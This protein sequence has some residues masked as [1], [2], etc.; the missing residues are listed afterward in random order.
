MDTIHTALT[1]NNARNKQILQS[2][3]KSYNKILSSFGF[4]E[5]SPTPLYF[6]KKEIPFSNLINFDAGIG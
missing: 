1:I 2:G 4:L 3:L 6:F 5:A